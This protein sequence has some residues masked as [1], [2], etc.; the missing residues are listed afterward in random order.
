[1]TRYARLLTKRFGELKCLDERFSLKSIRRRKKKFRGAL[2]FKVIGETK[3]VSVWQHL[4][5]TGTLLLP[6]VVVN[7]LLVKS[8]VEKVMN[9]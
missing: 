5:R 6:N 9:Q 7:K 2:Y 1:M 8:G 3:L 4:P